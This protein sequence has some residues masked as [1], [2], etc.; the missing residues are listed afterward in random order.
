MAT[1]ESLSEPPAGWQ[2][3]GS[4]PHRA[5]AHSLYTVGYTVRLRDYTVKPPRSDVIHTVRY[6]TAFYTGSCRLYV[7]GNTASMRYNLISHL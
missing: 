3:R 6:N 1:F 5:A 7:D 2:T 4:E